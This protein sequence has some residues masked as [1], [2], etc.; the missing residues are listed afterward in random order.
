MAARAKYLFDQ[1]FAAGGSAAEKHVAPS[2]H[3]IL[4]GEA[5]SKGFRDGFAAAEKEGTAVAARR[6]TVALE[7]IG[8]ALERLARGVVTVEQR[9]ESEAVA[10]AVAVARKLAPELVL[11]QPFAEIAALATECLKQLSTAPHVVVRVN[12]ALLETAST[13]LTDIARTRGFEGRLVVLAEPE[14]AIGDCKIE[15][16][17]G[18]VIRDQAKT[19]LT[20]GNAIGRY[21]GARQTAAMPELGAI[22]PGVTT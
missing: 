4:I 5:E 10:L 13:Q 12:D 11:R 1:D 9:L 20:I 21:L 18:G 7:Q 6:A 3:A 19:E 15:W 2:E 16:A 14:L 22:E 17:D 8:D